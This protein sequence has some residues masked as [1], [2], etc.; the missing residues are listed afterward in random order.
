MAFD[1]CVASLRGSMQLLES[2]ITL[3]DEGV[4]DLPRLSKALQA[5]RVCLFL[6]HPLKS[7][8][9]IFQSSTLNSPPNPTSNKPNTTSS[10]K[11]AQK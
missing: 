7:L 11:S 10:P 6:Q 2:S 9:L 3:L 8:I 1:G 5:T 4:N